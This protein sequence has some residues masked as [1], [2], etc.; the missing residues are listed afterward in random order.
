MS[1]RFVL[2]APHPLTND[3]QPAE[4]WVSTARRAESEGWYAIS[5]PDHVGGPFAR[6][7]APA[8]AL[9]AAA[10]ATTRLR[11]T[12]AVLAVDFRHPVVLAKELA[13]L[14]VLCGGRVE[15]G[16]GAGWYDDDYAALG[17]KKD[18]TSVRLERLAE[19][20]AVLRAAWADGPS[21]FSGSHY[22]FDELDGFPKPAQLGG[23]PITLGGAAPRSL[24]LAG[25][26]GD[27][28]NIAL[29]GTA[30]LHGNAVKGLRESLDDCIEWIREGAGDRFSG[31]RIG[32]RIAAAEI[33]D[34]PSAALSRRA[35]LIGTDEDVLAGSPHV[36]VGSQSL[37]EERIAE[38]SER[39][40]ITTL[41]CNGHDAW[42]LAPLLA[43]QASS[44]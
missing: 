31:L 28:V 38:L 9:T 4:A 13:T 34:D 1:V 30:L 42:G 17:L 8:V 26:L 16:L 43:A 27:A 33:T 44:E 11:V 32:L 21:S 3:S 41:V 20:V 12:T 6:Q 29:D 18:P 25:A 23:I 15:V 37:I 5:L 2:Q 10:M 22:R 14:D 36:L 35:G 40:G 39:W 7:W 24:R 19:A